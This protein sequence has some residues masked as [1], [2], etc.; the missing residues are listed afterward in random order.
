MGFF[1]CETASQGQTLGGGMTSPINWMIFSVLTIRKNPTY[2]HM[3]HA[4]QPDK[5]ACHHGKIV[6][7]RF[8]FKM[9]KV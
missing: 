9:R 3:E 5:D 2:V 8:N 7:W 6:A 1:L 4:C